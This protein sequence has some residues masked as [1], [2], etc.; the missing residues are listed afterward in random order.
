M[1]FKFS[2]WFFMAMALLGPLLELTGYIERKRKLYKKLVKEF[3]NDSLKWEMTIG[4]DLS[5][6]FEDSS[7]LFEK[8]QC[9]LTP[10]FK[11]ILDEFFPKFLG[12]LQDDKF[13]QHIKEIRIESHIDNVACPQLYEDLHVADAILSQKRV[14]NILK[15]LRSKSSEACSSDKLQKVFDNWITYNGVSC[16]RVLANKEYIYLS[17]KGE[18]LKDSSQIEF[19]IVT[20][21]DEFLENSVKGKIAIEA[22]KSAWEKWVIFFTVLIV[23]VTFLWFLWFL[24][25]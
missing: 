16:G 9:D 1:E 19:R 10:E 11:G 12:I 7:R 13:L 17:E 25:K 22:P 21:A 23:V 20:N 18:N 14:L 3:S 8:S 15:Y 4:E 2:F 24:R 5:I 6:K